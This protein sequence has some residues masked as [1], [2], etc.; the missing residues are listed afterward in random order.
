M[1]VGGC[2]KLWFIVIVVEV[3][4]VIQVAALFGRRCEMEVA[5]RNS[6]ISCC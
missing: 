2:F 3:V 1:V 5:L 4:I 6:I